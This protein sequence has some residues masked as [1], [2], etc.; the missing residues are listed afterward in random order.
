MKYKKISIGLIFVFSLAV[1]FAK[2]FNIAYLNKTHT[3][4]KINPAIFEAF[5]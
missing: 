5:I 2:S 4:L 3:E 1:A